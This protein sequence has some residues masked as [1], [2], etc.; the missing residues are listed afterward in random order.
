MPPRG[1]HGWKIQIVTA[2]ERSRHGIRACAGGE[3]LLAQLFED[4]PVFELSGRWIS[5]TTRKT[6]LLFPIFIEELT[7]EL[8]GKYFTRHTSIVAIGVL[9]TF[10]FAMPI[11]VMAR[12]VDTAGVFM[13]TLWILFM[14]LMIGSLL[15][16]ALMSSFK[17]ALRT[18]TGWKEFFPG[19][20]ILAGFGG[21]IFFLL[22]KLAAGV[23]IS[24]AVMLVA[25]LL[26]NLGW[27]PRLKRKSTLG[28]QAADEI[29]GFRQFLMKTEQDRLDRISAPDATDQEF[30]R[31]LPY[32]IALEVKEAWGD[33][34]S[35]EFLGSVIYVEG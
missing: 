3:A 10:L 32:A 17:T 23:S 29:A 25:F 30:T 5:A 14:G 28:R 11:A 18:R 26:V 27:G 21:I 15:E 24:F 2:H 7:K 13:L 34:L 4:G 33:H 9:I 19:F 6:A 35:Q 31:H 1:I 20:W 22:K 12:G 8:G 16:T